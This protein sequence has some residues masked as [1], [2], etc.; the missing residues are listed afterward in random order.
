MYAGTLTPEA[1]LVAG[2]FVERTLAEHPDRMLPAEVLIDTLQDVE[3]VDGAVLDGLAVEL[4]R[5]LALL[6]GLS[7]PCFPCDVHADFAGISDRS[8]AIW[9]LSQ[10]QQ[11]DDHAWPQPSPEALF[12]ALGAARLLAADPLIVPPQR[13]QTASH[14][15]AEAPWP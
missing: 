3:R 4:G 13:R 7:A 15:P 14:R 9:V 6:H 12:L 11:L 10:A 5:R 2:A 8:L 1:L